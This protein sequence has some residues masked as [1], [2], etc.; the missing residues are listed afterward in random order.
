MGG[1][2]AVMETFFFRLAF[3]CRACYNAPMKTL[4]YMKKLMITALCAALC[5]V[6]PWAF[7]MIPDA[8]SVLC[9][10]HISVLLCGLICG[11][12]WG[13]F[14]GISG[15][16]LSS[17]ITQ[18]PPLGY[19]P[20]MLV[21][22]AVYGLVSGICMRWIRTGKYVVDLYSSLLCG[23]L[24]G[25]V[26]AG[27]AQ[28]LIFSAGDYSPALWVTSYFVTA[29]P[30]IV[31]QLIFV[32]AIVLTLKKAKLIPQ[33]AADKGHMEFAKYLQAQYRLHPSMQMQ[34]AVKLCY[35][36]ALGAEH[37]L[38]DLGAAERYFDEEYAKTEERE[39]PLFEEISAE[40]CRVNL[41]AW[42]AKG[43]PSAWLFRM[44]AASV[45]TA[46]GKREL[47]S[48]YIATAQKVLP[49][50]DRKSF[51]EA[52]TAAGMPA[53]HHSEAYRMAEKPAYRIVDRRFIRLLPILEK[54]AALPKGDGAC[55]IALEGRAAAGK[56]TAAALL[57]E[58]LGA[59]VVHMDDFFLP[60]AQRSEERLAEPGGNIHYERF[61]AEVLPHVACAECFSY[62]I[63]DCGKMELDG[64][65]E[66]CA[67]SYRI[68]EGA[69]SCHPTFGAYADCKV[70]F[71]IA[72]DMQ[73]QRILARNG[74]QMAEMFKQRWIPLEEMY[75]KSYRVQECADIVVKM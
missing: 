51:L 23:M 25:R 64:E 20:G 24:C 65:R 12:Q 3:F 4:T 33:R 21:E 48:E 50:A 31:M 49:L 69:Y 10:M 57:A 42:K 61:V 30:G 72:P 60:P 32:P 54:I 16:F 7:H 28:S 15:P 38:T 26:A 68:V 75:Y 71:D 53:V 17:V 9:P 58:I 63:F 62:R 40:V 43:L 70:F 67:S 37:L 5:V 13:F 55:V 18:M 52:Y 29:L 41:G 47:F 46:R 34:D 11:W 56:S 22:L 73:M 74:A 8:G 36:A 14:C 39:Q 35:Q 1:F 45:R 6:L 2:C 44:F 59:G 19:L 27:M 66:V